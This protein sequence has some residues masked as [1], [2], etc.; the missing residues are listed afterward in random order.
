MNVFMDVKLALSRPV[1]P[2][3][4]CFSLIFILIGQIYASAQSFFAID[5]AMRSQHDLLKDRDVDSPKNTT[6]DALNTAFFGEYVPKNISDA[7]VKRSMLRFTVVGIMYANHQENSHVIIRTKGGHE[8]SFNV[9]DS[10]PGDVII[11]RITPDGV[12]IRHN[13]A[14][15]SL[16]LPKNTLTF[17]APAKP[18]RSSN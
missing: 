11:K 8:K 14:L 2:R 7:D 6:L 4:I 10:L 16:S 17:E 5:N 12:L 13:G 18:L 15:E 3:L 1:V 9:G